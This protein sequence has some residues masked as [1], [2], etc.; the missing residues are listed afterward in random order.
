MLVVILNS[1]RGS[2]VAMLLQLII[3]HQLFMNTVF[4]YKPIHYLI[5]I[6]VLYFLLPI[7]AYYK[8]AGLEGLNNYL[9]YNTK[10]EVVQNY[11]DPLK[12]IVGDLG[13][14][15]IQAP[16]LRGVLE[17]KIEPRYWP[18]TYTAGLLLVVPSSI[19]P[20]FAS[21]KTVV[22]AEAQINLDTSV[23]LYE[24]PKGEIISTRIYS[25]LGEG[26][27]NFG[28]I[29]IPFLFFIFGFISRK[30]FYLAMDKNWPANLTNPY[31]SLLPIFILFYDFDNIIFQS[32]VVW[33]FPLIVLKYL[34][35][36]SFKSK[37]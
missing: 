3:A 23:P 2:R 13:R 9:N 33:G 19:R 15:D 30:A 14:A 5:G 1:A 21:P 10:A 32:I 25:F 20:Q 11:N 18:E 26:V 29:S 34:S 7:Y 22:G 35:K 27:L 4:Q 8:Y 12:F 36:I 6:C 31:F 24:N 17:G 16:I 37:P 28:I